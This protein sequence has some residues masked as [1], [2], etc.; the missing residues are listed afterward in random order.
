[1]SDILPHSEKNEKKKRYL[2]LTYLSQL[3]F[4]LLK[5]YVGTKK[6][7]GELKGLCYVSYMN[8]TL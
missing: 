7:D 4:S 3:E 2:L 1:M 6:K 5:N 8:G